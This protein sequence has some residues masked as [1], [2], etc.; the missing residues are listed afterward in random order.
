MI[1]VVDLYPTIASL[2]GASTEDCK[3]LDGLNVWNTLA[4]NAPSPRTEFFYNIEPFRAAMR[5]GNWKLV[6]RNLLP[7]EVLLYDLEADPQESN[8][9]AESH[10]ELV[11]E[12]QDKINQA[13]KE[14]AKPLFLM[15]QFKVVMFNMNGEPVLPTAEGFGE[16][17]HH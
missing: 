17:E 14:A 7:A 2:A 4:S 1:H 13:A 11:A 3:P 15:D 9:L 16:V 12:M 6:W 10:P 5:Q 8:N